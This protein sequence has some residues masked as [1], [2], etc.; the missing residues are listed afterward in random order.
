MRC[1]RR[2][3]GFE[4][5]LYASVDKRWGCAYGYCVKMQRAGKNRTSCGGQVIVEYV[6][7]AGVLVFVGVLMALLL[8]T[9][10]ENGV[11]V[12]DLI[13]SDHP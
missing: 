11:R 7:T 10:R 5:P 2:C 6:V 12:L 9:F 13:A 3:F 4:K 8:Y 1:R